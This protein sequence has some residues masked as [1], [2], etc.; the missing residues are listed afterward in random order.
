[1]DDIDFAQQ[2]DEFYRQIALDRWQRHRIEPP[3]RLEYEKTICVD[4]GDMIDQKRLRANPQAMRC[5]FCQEKKE[6]GERRG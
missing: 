2:Q 4:C 6:R 1:M 5:I 3:R